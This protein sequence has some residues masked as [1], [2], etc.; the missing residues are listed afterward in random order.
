VPTRKAIAGFALS[1]VGM[2]IAAAAFA[3]PDGSNNETLP[4]SDELPEIA[5]TV[6]SLARQATRDVAGVSKERDSLV[7][8]APVIRAPAPVEALPATRA[9]AVGGTSS[10]SVNA[11]SEQ[12]AAGFSVRL[13]V[14]DDVALASLARTLVARLTAH[15]IEAGLTSLD[16]AGR[17]NV[18]LALGLD[19]EQ[20]GT[21]A[22]YCDAGPQLSELLAAY[23]IEST[24]RLLRPE[25]SEPV[26]A[27]SAN[28]PL[29][30]CESVHSG[31]AQT[32]GV[33]VELPPSIVIDVDAVA[34]VTE[35]LADGIERYLIENHKSVR[36]A[37]DAAQLVWPARGALT[38]H[39]GPSHPLGIDIGQRGGN[40]VAAM[41]GTVV[42]AG[43]DPCCSYGRFVVIDNEASGLRTVY[44]HLASLAVRQGQKVRR[45]Q[46]LGVVGCSGHC[47]GT[48]LHFEVLVNGVRENPLNYLP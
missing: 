18:L 38:S 26:A 36:Q 48:H 8:A 29:F 5:V 32:A 40:V 1:L 22:W 28:E 20:A 14:G 39:Y 2:L 21:E 44:G 42:F 6:P 35:S 47:D 13:L 33:L 37:R 41:D 27:K 46:T 34:S 9:R 4:I 16:D 12:S 11:R 24:N 7:T 15:G 31:R 25:Y 23:V 45:G 43:G 10:P 30:P 17:P 3:S 19:R